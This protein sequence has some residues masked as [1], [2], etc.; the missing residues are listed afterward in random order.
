MALPQP[1]DGNA[2]GTYTETYAYDPFGNFL[3]MVH[4]VSSGSWTRPYAYREPSQITPGETSNR[5]TAT[6][7]PGDPA[8]GPYS[9]KY[10][11]DAH[12]NM[13]T[14]PH[15]P[16]MSWD[17][18]DRLRSTTR[19][20]VNNGTPET[21]Y[22]AYDGSGQRVR[23]ATESQAPAGQT[24]TRA[25]ERLY[26]GEVEIYREFAGD[27][28]TVTLERETLRV[29]AV[30][31]AVCLVETRTIGS[32]PAPAKLVRY[33]YANHLGSAS[34]ELD[35]G[36]Q[37]ISYE[38]YFPFGST[39]YQ[40]VRRQAETPKR[41]RFTG[42]E[43]D[44][45]NDLNY[46]GARYYAPWLGRWTACDPLVSAGG[47]SRYVYAS[48][49][50]ARLHDPN[51]RDPTDAP[52]QPA[53]PFVTGPYGQVGGDHVHQV[54]ARTANPGAARTT[55]P[56]YRGALSISTKNPNYKDANAQKVER[57]INRASW[58]QDYD[59]RPADPKPIQPG[60]KGVVR[61]TATG[62][63]DVGRTQPAAASQS[64]EDV[65]SYYKQRVCWFSVN[66]T[67]RLAL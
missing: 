27:G 20:V 11:Y 59:E 44:E 31:Q 64:L 45:E 19:Q 63:T 24:P 17:E 7:L 15:L 67:D 58:G 35:D 29:N 33:Q 23:K 43:R 66:G 3:A 48:N 13:V 42:K 41:Y 65:K 36:A 12:G 39:S 30:G 34:L 57:A 10:T 22:Y 37:I 51:G 47:E 62:T 40:A 8:A 32:D 1:G 18:Q 46:H 2:M 50:P 26:L 14:M 4:Q 56:L 61:V 38:E 52:T 55:A 28:M 53:Q 5:L 25:A 49:S 9:A 16:A 21:T 6:G 54:A 60:S